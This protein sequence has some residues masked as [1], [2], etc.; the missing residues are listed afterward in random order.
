VLAE[1][2]LGLDPTLTRG[3]GDALWRPLCDTYLEASLRPA[4]AAALSA[5]VEGGVSLCEDLVQGARDLED[6]AESLGIV[7]GEHWPS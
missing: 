6:W 3:L 2:G 5:G 1:R 4:A 7:E